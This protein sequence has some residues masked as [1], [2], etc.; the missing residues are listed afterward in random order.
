MA[1][2]YNF[3]L[4]SLDGALQGAIID[5]SDIFLPLYS[6]VTE[7]QVITGGK[8]GQIL[9]MAEAQ[10]EYY[11]Y[12]GSCPPMP[13]NF[14]DMPYLGAPLISLG[15]REAANGSDKYPPIFVQF[16]FIDKNILDKNPELFL[17]VYRRK[18]QRRRKGA[19]YPNEY[20]RGKKENQNRFVHPTHLDGS[21]YAGSS[22]FTGVQKGR[23]GQLLTNRVT[24][25]SLDISKPYEKQKIYVNPY[26]WFVTEIE[27]VNTYGSNFFNNTP[28]IND[29]AES[30]YVADTIQMTA[31]HFII[32]KNSFQ[33]TI[34]S[35]AATFG[36]DA[37]TPKSYHSPKSLYFKLALAID[38][39][40]YN[41]LHPTKKYNIPKIIGQMSDTFSIYLKKGF[42][43]ENQRVIYF[44]FT[45]KI[46]AGKQGFV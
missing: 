10:A 41:P 31:G 34:S 39:P 13:I 25:W 3:K 21:K 5:A 18:L 20:Q 28:I 15:H 19:N 22:F 46:F 44:G 40:E 26:D 9:T 17:F 4:M 11:G 42:D 7:W 1:S 27:G 14:D 29:T 24:E 8:A 35:N 30:S 43:K 16:P 2:C 33:N 12:V 45:G 6:D 32:S 37:V 38:N 36:L 23:D